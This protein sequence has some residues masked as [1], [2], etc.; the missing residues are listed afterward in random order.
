MSTTD[1]LAASSVDGSATQA[2]PPSA[3]DAPAAAVIEAFG[4][5]RTFGEIQAV[6]GLDL[7]VR[8]G[9]IFGFLGPNGAGKSTT[10][11]MLVGLMEPTAGSCKVLG[12]DLP[13]QANQLSERVGYMTQKFSLY[14]DLTVEENLDFAAEIFGIEPAERAIRVKEAMIEF[15]LLER[16]KQLPAKLSGGWRQRLALAVATIHR[17]ELLV[18]DEPTAGVDP[19]SRRVFWEKLFRMA[20]SGTTILVST[21]YMDEAI[22]C[23]RLCVIRDGLRVALASPVELVDSVLPRVLEFHGKHT[24]QLVRA[25]HNE[26]AVASVVQLGHRAH[27]LLE[28]DAG[29]RQAVLANLIQRL[30]QQGLRVTGEL[31]DAHLE[32]ALIVLSRGETLPLA[33]ASGA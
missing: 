3:E 20:D 21:H 28:A 23:H 8:R 10:I 31:A 19:D 25:L 11:R 7:E 16:R 12:F 14:T 24:G 17:P 2:T 4:L 30:E 29:D 33:E 32:D 27:V 5:K 15:D 9:E 26:P 18:L 1:A 6:R 13:K 22:R